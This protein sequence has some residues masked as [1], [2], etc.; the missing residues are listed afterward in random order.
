MPAHPKLHAA[1]GSKSVPVDAAA[2]AHAA[3]ATPG[4]DRHRIDERV[5]VDS[6]ADLVRRRT[7]V[8]NQF[9]A[10]TP[11]S[12]STTHQATSPAGPA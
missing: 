9:E 7:M 4:L 12:G 10:Y 11:T 6:R 1:T 5:L 8:I 3:I 2:L